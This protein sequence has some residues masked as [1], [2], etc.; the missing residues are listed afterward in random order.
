M[1]GGSPKGWV[2]TRWRGVAGGGGNGEEDTGTNLENGARRVGANFRALV[3]RLGGFC[4]SPGCLQAAGVSQND[5]MLPSPTQMHIL[6]GPI[7][8]EDPHTLK[9]PTNTHSHV[10]RGTVLA[11]KIGPNRTWPELN[12]AQVDLA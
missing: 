9:P 4:A 12:L 8:R 5:P 7:Q 11:R 6:G 3:S 1:K 10:E 2:P